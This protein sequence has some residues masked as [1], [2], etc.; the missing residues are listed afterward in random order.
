MLQS[1][2]LMVYIQY[3]KKSI[4]FVIEGN[5]GRNFVTILWIRRISSYFPDSAQLTLMMPDV[6]DIYLPL[7]QSSLKN[8]ATQNAP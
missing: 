7:V 3:F 6:D 8:S 2:F 1:S 5:L 4:C